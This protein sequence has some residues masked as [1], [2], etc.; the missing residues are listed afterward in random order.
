M[1]VLSIVSCPVRGHLMF[2]YLHD[3]VF[4][5]FDN[6]ID[7]LFVLFIYSIRRNPRQLCSAKTDLIRRITRSFINQTRNTRIRNL[8]VEFYR[9]TYSALCVLTHIVVK[10]VI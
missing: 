4:Y 10:S 3:V 1:F 7:G 6:R 9:Y 5:R 2:H 8:N